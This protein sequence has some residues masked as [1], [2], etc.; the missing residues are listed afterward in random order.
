MGIIT[1]HPTINPT[2]N[3]STAAPSD[4]LH[5]SHRGGGW[6]PEVGVTDGAFEVRDVM[7]SI[8]EE[9]SPSPDWRG[10]SGFGMT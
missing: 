8:R 1:I 3:P 10:R 5:H 7:D 4:R 6:H 2:I 9:V